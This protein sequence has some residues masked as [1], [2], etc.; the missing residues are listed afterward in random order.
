MDSHSRVTGYSIDSL[1]KKMKSVAM[2]IIIEKIRTK[3][4]YNSNNKIATWAYFDEVH[5]FWKDEYAMVELDSTWREVRK[6][7]GLATGM[8]QMILDGLQNPETK[9]MIS[10]SEFAIMVEQGS[11][12]KENLFDVFN[13]SNEQLSYVNGVEPGTGIIRAG[14][15]IIP[16]DNIVPRDNELYKLYNTSFHDEEA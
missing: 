13:I 8:T 9:A 15:K 2:L 11:I 5:E 1:G 7:G 10:N 16:F 3:I 12:D 14:R 4:K 6:L